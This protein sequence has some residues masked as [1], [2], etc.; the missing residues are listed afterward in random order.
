[1]TPEEKQQ[2]I[3]DLVKKILRDSMLKRIAPSGRIQT[4]H[5]ANE[6]P[7]VQGSMVGMRSFAVG[8]D[9]ELRGIFHTELWKPGENIAKCGIGCDRV[10]GE[11][12]PN[13]QCNCGFHG[14]HNGDNDFGEELLGRVTAVVEAYGKVI[15]GDRGFRAEKARILAIVDPTL[16]EERPKKPWYKHLSFSTFKRFAVWCHRLKH[17]FTIVMSLWLIGLVLGML[18]EWL[19]PVPDDVTDYFSWAGL[20]FVIVSTYGGLLD[21][22]MRPMNKID[23]KAIHKRYPD[24]KYYR[25]RSDMLAAHPLTKPGTP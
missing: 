22:K 4:S 3:D 19:T 16:E 9:G 13:M 11:K 25:T 20:L 6:A 1:M 17:Q 23:W 10:L 18:T 15:V 2:R 21:I 14:Y 8:D 24:V 5:Y 12:S 7:F